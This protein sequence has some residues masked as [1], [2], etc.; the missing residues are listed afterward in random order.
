[1]GI[2]EAKMRHRSNLSVLELS[3]SDF[4]DVQDILQE[5][6]VE[7]TYSVDEKVAFLYGS[8]TELDEVENILWAIQVLRALELV[9]CSRSGELTTSETVSKTS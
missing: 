7:L 8:E 3:L 6:G 4:R 5:R 2:I 9:F 1:M